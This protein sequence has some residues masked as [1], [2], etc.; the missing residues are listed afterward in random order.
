MNAF[1]RYKTACET[2]YRAEKRREA[3][4]LKAFPVGSTITYEHGGHSITAEVL[5]PCGSDGLK[6]RGWSSG[7]EH[8]LY[9]SRV[10]TVRP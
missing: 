4:M 1:N 6:V 5:A 3:A 7:K 10:V 2:V 8:R 9:A